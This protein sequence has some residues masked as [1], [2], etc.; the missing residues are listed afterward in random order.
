[1]KTILIIEDDAQTREN[2]QL[3][4]EM[5]GFRALTAPHGKAGLEMANRMALDLVLCDVSM[6]ELDG[7]GVLREL[8]AEPRTANVPFIFLT[9]RGEKTDVRAGMNL[10]ADD[11]L[12]K[13]LDAEDLLTA[14]ETRLARHDRLHSKGLSPDFSSA[15]PLEALGLTPREA[16]VLLWVAQ[17]KS[18]SDVGTILSMSDKTV[19]IHL[20]H[21]FEKLIIKTR[22]AASLLAIEALPRQQPHQQGA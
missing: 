1:M 2:L 8:R 20:R 13:P 21:I 4:L 9:A 12:T 15:A 3:I 16:E 17:G 7:H 18:N 6:P 5:E 11:Y 22:T 10:G 19:M 14:I